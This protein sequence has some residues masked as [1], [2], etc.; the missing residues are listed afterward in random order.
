VRQNEPF[1]ES[2]NVLVLAFG[3]SALLV[4]CT[5]PSIRSSI[6]QT[7]QSKSEVN[8]ESVAEVRLGTPAKD[9]VSRFGVPQ[10]AFILSDRSEF[11][12]VYQND[13]SRPQRTYFG[14]DPDKKVLTGKT[15]E[16]Q[17]SER[18]RSSKAIQAYFNGADFYRPEASM[19]GSHY[20]LNAGTAFLLGTGVSL[21][22]HPQSETVQ[23]VSWGPVR[24]KPR[25]PAQLPDGCP[26]GPNIMAEEIADP[27][28]LI[29]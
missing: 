27:L 29:R 14:F 21:T 25:H 16:P 2:L 6:N 8:F 13:V 11:I 28:T 18:F 7:Q 26:K 22:I 19:C 17:A 5:G 20:T 15:Y 12:L 4:S 24:P 1:K 3:F 23:A 9:I 10:K